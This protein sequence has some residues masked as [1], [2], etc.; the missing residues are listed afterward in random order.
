MAAGELPAGRA[1]DGGAAVLFA[2]GE[3][4]EVVAERP[5]P[6]LHRVEPGNGGTMGETAL[7][8]RVLP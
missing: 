4:T 6:T 7:P 5:G 1:P 2:D 3:L 8:A